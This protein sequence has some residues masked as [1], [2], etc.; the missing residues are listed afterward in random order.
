MSMNPA[1]VSVLFVC[2]GNICRSPTADGVFQGLVSQAGLATKIK[3]DSAGTAAWHIG[4]QPDPRSQKAAANRGYDL[5][6]LQ[7]RQ[8]NADDFNRFDLILA[9]DQA[10]YN[11]LMLLQPLHSKAHLALFLTYA[12]DLG[13]TEVPDPYYGGA[14]GFEQVLDL[15]EVAGRH[16]LSHL[17]QQYQLTA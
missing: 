17:T 8:V 11:D 13:V 12:P 10:N 7:A 5:S 14:D 9:M 3:V 16:L 2:L 6:R 15:V 4:K 1:A